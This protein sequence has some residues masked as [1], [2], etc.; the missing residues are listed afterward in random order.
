MVSSM[1]KWSCILVFCKHLN[2][3]QQLSINFNFFS[4]GEGEEAP[5][6]GWAVRK[7]MEVVSGIFVKGRQ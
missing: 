5:W 1:A 2:C 4:I 7:G 3:L 6:V